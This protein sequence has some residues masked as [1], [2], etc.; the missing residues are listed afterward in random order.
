M[1]TLKKCFCISSTNA[2]IY[3]IGKEIEVLRK[4]VLDVF[5]KREVYGIG[6]FGIA[7]EGTSGGTNGILCHLRRTA[8]YADDECLVGFEDDASLLEAKLL[9]GE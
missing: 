5:R 7:Q 2:D 6:N 3:D 8:S 4:R 9:S 1:S